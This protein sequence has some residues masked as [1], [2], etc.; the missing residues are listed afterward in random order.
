MLSKAKPDS[1]IIVTRETSKGNRAKAGKLVNLCLAHING[2]L[3]K[4]RLLSGIVAGELWE[5]QRVWPVDTV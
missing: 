2:H 4:K 5:Y 3:L 1:V